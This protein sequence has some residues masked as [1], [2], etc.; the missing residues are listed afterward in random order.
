M[1]IVALRRTALPALSRPRRQTPTPPSASASRKRIPPQSAT[2]KPMLSQVGLELGRQLVPALQLVE[3]L[4]GHAGAGSGQGGRRREARSNR[5]AAAECRRAP[6]RATSRSR[7]MRRRRRLRRRGGAAARSSGRRAGSRRASQAP[8]FQI[9]ST[10]IRRI[11]AE[12]T[13]RSKSPVDVRCN[14]VSSELEPA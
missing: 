10:T 3:P 14:A 6:G 1:I 12:A 7:A 2:T 4:P 5:G 11:A 13:A 8:G 9:M